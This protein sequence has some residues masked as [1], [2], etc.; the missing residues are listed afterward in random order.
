MKER[1]KKRVVSS[2]KNCDMALFLYEIKPKGK[3]NFLIIFL[4]IYINTMT[5]KENAI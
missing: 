5:R 2:R 1:R 4:K 3:I